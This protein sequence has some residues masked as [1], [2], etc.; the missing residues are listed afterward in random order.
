MFLKRTVLEIDLSVVGLKPDLKSLRIVNLTG[1]WIL[2]GLHS[3]KDEWLTG[4]SLELR[5]VD[6]IITQ[7]QR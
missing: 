6:Q 7:Q 5:L 1:V 3:L 2:Q 4:Y